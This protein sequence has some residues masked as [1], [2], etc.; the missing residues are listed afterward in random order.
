MFVCVYAHVCVLTD[1]ATYVEVRGQLTGL[2]LLLPS[3]GAWGLSSS[4]QAWQQATLSTEPLHQPQRR[5]LT[6]SQPKDK[7]PHQKCKLWV[8]NHVC[9]QRPFT[10]GQNQTKVKLHWGQIPSPLRQLLW[11]TNGTQLSGQVLALHAQ[12]QGFNSQHWNICTHARLHACTNAP[13]HTHQ[14]NKNTAQTIKQGWE[15]G[16][17]R[18]IYSW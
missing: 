15:H 10:N 5:T 3:Y 2:S 8:W 11:E 7:Q 12:R 9:F 18:N 13:T 4:P 14:T 6:T 17:R 1:H 16:G